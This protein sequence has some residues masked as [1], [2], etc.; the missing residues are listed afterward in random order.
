MDRQIRQGC[1]GD[2]VMSSLPRGRRRGFGSHASRRRSGAR[3]LARARAC[4]AGSGRVQVGVPA[5]VVACN[6]HPLPRPSLKGEGVSAAHLSPNPVIAIRAAEKTLS[7]RRPC[8]AAGRADGRGGRIV[9]SRAVGLRQE[10]A[11]QHGGG[12]ARAVRRAGASGRGRAGVIRVS[13]GNVDALGSRGGQRALAA[14]PC[15]HRT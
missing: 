10:H 2:A 3:M 1:E 14:G 12:F 6:R 11:A 8:A 7:Q 4:K 15:G 9:T 13:G 5:N